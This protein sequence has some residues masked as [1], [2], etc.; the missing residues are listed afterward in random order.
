MVVLILAVLTKIPDPSTSEGLLYD[1]FP[2]YKQIK[3][4]HLSICTQK[5]QNKKINTREITLDTK[6]EKL[7]K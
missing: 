7:Y 6:I 2:H 4:F 1:T 5:T 3:K